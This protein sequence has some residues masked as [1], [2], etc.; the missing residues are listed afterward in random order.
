LFDLIRDRFFRGLLQDFLFKFHLC[1]AFP[2]EAAQH[3]TCGRSIA[4]PSPQTP[5]GGR[6]AAERGE[7]QLQQ[8]RAGLFIAQAAV[9]AA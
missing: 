1:L 9:P 7:A 2:F 3:R 8:G 5:T 6:E 4:S